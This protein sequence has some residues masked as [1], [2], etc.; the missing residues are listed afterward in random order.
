[1]QTLLGS[2]HEGT[3]QTGS[4][5]M[6]EDTEWAEL[7]L[8]LKAPALFFHG[9]AGIEKL[10]DSTWDDTAVLHIWGTHHGVRFPASSL[11]V[12]KNADLVAVQG[13]LYQLSNLL[14][15]LMLQGKGQHD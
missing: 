13:A 12:R 14:E 7:C 9:L 1:M 10:V 15:N 11:P 6:Y 5:G 2:K 3:R 4:R 8:H